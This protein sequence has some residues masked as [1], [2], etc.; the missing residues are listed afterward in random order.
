MLQVLAH[1][2]SFV[3]SKAVAT[4]VMVDEEEGFM[5]TAEEEKKVE[6]PKVTSKNPIRQTFS[7]A[8]FVLS[9]IQPTPID[10]ITLFALCQ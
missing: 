3:D 5:E 10:M 4:D 1:L 8:S 9:Y 7:G 6:Q 2:L